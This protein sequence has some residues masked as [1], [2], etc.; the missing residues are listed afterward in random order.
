MRDVVL[1]R[2]QVVVLPRRATLGPLNGEVKPNLR[3]DL[4][5]LG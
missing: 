2:E 5:R 3:S 1:L 4:A